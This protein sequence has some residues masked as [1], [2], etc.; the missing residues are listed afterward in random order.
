MCSEVGILEG[1]WNIEALY[2]QEINL[3]MHCC[4]VRSQSLVGGADHWWCDLAGYI[5]VSGS[6]LLSLLPVVMRSAAFLYHD[7]YLE[8]HFCL[9]T[10]KP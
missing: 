9:R 10:N 3:L 7:F 6:H 5:L 8:G 4:V 1:D 2:S